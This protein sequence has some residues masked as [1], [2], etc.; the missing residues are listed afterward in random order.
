METIV[1]I[2]KKG[3]SIL[4][5]TDTVWGLGCDAT[6]EKSVENIFRI[7]KRSESKSLIVLVNSISMLKEYVESVSNEALGI[8]ETA[9][10]PTTI[11][12]PN[13]K[14]L[15]NNVI[16]SDN[17]VAIRV[18]KHEFCEELIEKLGKPI[19]STSANVSGE[20]TPKSFSEISQPI[21]ES[22]DYVV[23][24]QQ[25]SSSGVSS[26]ILKLNIDGSIDVIRD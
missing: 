10:R 26:R 1:E 21:L 23:D 8:L 9:T 13:P 20:P 11:V 14:G 7:K 18:V 24:L 3:S 17:T 19:V 2:V 4:Y 5:P 6:N 12:Y 15:A 25:N 22:V 16:A